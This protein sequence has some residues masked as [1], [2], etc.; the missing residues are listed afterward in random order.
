MARRSGAPARRLEVALQVRTG[1]SCVARI[2]PVD[3]RQTRQRA[4]HV[5]QVNVAGTIVM[6]QVTPFDAGRRP[7]HRGKGGVRQGV[8]ITARPRRCRGR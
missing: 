4:A 2:D 7:L 6:R 5:T 1:C 3:L 8:D